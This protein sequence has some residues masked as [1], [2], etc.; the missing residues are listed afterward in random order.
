MIIWKKEWNKI[1][2]IPENYLIYYNKFK[3]FFQKNLKSM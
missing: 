2:N 1:K 3:D